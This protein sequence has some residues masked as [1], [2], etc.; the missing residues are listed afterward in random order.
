MG[1]LRTTTCDQC[2]SEAASEHHVTWAR[3]DFPPQ[4]GDEVHQHCG[5]H[6]SECVAALDAVPLDHPS[7]YYM[8][9]SRTFTRPRTPEEQQQG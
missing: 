7:R 1:E 2:E 5:K 8:Q 9:W 6:H 4:Q 3:G